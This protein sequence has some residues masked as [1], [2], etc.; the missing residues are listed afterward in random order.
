MKYFISPEKLIEMQDSKDNLVILDCRYLDGNPDYI[1]ETYEYQHIKGALPINIETE[2]TGKVTDHTGN[3]PLPN[4][5]KLK[6]VLED[7]GISNDSIVVGY[8]DG[9]LV[10]PSRMVLTLEL[11]GLKNLYV[12]TE[13]LMGYLGA[14]GI[15]EEGPAPEVEKKGSIDMNLDLS[16]IVDIDYLR[17]HKYDRDTVLIDSR[18]P[19]AYEYGHIPGAEN[20]FTGQIKERFSLVELEK[21]EEEFKELRN[22]KEV[23]ISCGSGMVASLTSLAMKEIGL[24][25]KFYI[26]GYSQWSKM[27]K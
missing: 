2:L 27:D 16:N 3:H 18:N 26:D 15:T 12:M 6:A 11:M 8:D 5:G 21:I 13:G 22:H 9:E 25:H 19:L 20:Y 10:G 24:D 14:G 7:L 1:Y 4:F 23:I 17:Q